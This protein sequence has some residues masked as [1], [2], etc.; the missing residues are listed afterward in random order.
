MRPRD[1]K[2]VDAVVAVLALASSGCAIWILFAQLTMLSGPFGFIVCW[3]GAFLLI[4]WIA[5]FQLYGSRVAADRLVASIVTVGAF[6][7]IVPLVLLTVYVFI[8]GW[9]LLSPHLFVGTEQGVTSDHLNRAG[10]A[11]AIIGT[12][13]QVGVAAVMGIPAAVIT[14]VF[15]NEVGGR[16]TRYVRVVVTAMS[17]TP[18]ILAGLFIYSIW[19]VSFHQGFSG[20]AGAMALAILLLPTVTRG[21]EEV[22]KVVHNE[23][24]EASAALGAPEWRTVWSVVL[25]TARSGLVTAILLGIAV[26]VGE[27]A[28]LLLTIFGSTSMN[29]NVLHGPQAA[30]PLVAYEQVKSQSAAAVAFGYTTSLV[31]FLMMFI[32]FLLSRIL[33]SQWLGN[34]LRRR[35]GRPQKPETE[36]QQERAEIGVI[37]AMPSKE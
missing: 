28:P 30:L 8:K 5:N 11:H 13:E 21:T 34:Q 18:A 1:F 12:L 3:F 36:L 9:H 27:T 17:G 35:R 23:L 7:M 2:P 15:I 33:G 10:L 20:F 31:L 25:P 32:L 26:S 37:G 22:L 6:G 19:I 24:R 16:F 14:A 4:Y 29:W